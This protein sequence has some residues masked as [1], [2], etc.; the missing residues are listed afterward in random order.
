M[1]VPVSMRNEILTACHDNVLSGHLGF[2]KTYRKL[3]ERFFW[4]LMY[5]DC[6]FWC[7]SCIDCSTRK[8]PK[9]LAKAPLLPIPSSYPFE[10]LAVDVSGPFP[11]SLQGN[12]FII[13]FTDTFT[14]WPEAFAVKS[15]NKETT[16]QLLVEE[17]ICRFG[18]PENLLS[19]RGKNFLSNL[20]LAVCK[21]LNTDKQNTT[22]YH[23]QTNSI[24][25][26]FNQTFATMMSM[27]VSSHH[28]DWDAFIPFL[29]FAYRSTVQESTL[30]SPFFLNF[31]RDPRLPI[32]IATRGDYDV[33]RDASDYRAALVSHLENAVALARDNVQ[34]AQ[35]KRKQ[36]FDHQAKERSFQLGD[37]VWL[38]TP[39]KQVGKSPKLIHF[40]HGPFRI[41]EQTSPVNYKLTSCDE[42]R[43]KFL[44]H[45]YRLKPYTDPA[46][47]PW[48]VMEPVHPEELGKADTDFDSEDDLPL[49]KWKNLK[50]DEDDSDVIDIT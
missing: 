37:R 45:V 21:L 32:D 35:Q 2:K 1:V 16:A 46:E 19:D 27:Y 15:A 14:R 49:A 6:E 26:R 20:V 38:F 17:I 13:V 24:C 41:T 43:R 9:S 25:E 10:T 48:R 29:L 18:A 44:V 39:Q 22:A 8:T 31:G 7:K 36:H 42:R 47:Q 30:E 50:D 11:T 40:W 3:R 5:S 33:H 23:P 28:K 34:L 12:R 4:P